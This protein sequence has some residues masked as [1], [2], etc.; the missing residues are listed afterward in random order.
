M[1]G[2][3][4]GGRER[5]N[6]LDARYILSFACYFIGT[7]V[8]RKQNNVLGASLTSSQNLISE[9]ALFSDAN[10]RT[11]SQP[12]QNYRHLLRQAL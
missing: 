4:V 11:S 2:R 5:S 1:A 10:L 3:A 6:R 12:Y 9:S 8:P 7:S